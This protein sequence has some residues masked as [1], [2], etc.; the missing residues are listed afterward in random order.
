[1]APVLSTKAHARLLEVDPDEAL[2]M[3]GV[4]DYIS[5]KDI[6]AS[7]SYTFTAEDDEIVFATDRVRTVHYEKLA[8]LCRIGAEF[9]GACIGC[10]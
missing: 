5:Y 2:R 10:K 3:P 8:T 7:N 6:P 1:M 9:A 4:V